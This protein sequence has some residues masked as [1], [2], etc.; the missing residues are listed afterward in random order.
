LIYFADILLDI[1]YS[2]ILFLILVFDIFTFVLFYAVQQYNILYISKSNLDTED[3]IYSKILNQLFL[4]LYIIEIYFIELFCLVR[5]NYNQ[6]VCFK[7][8]VIIILIAIFI[9][10]YQRTVNQNYQLYFEYLSVY[11]KKEV[12]NKNTIKFLKLQKQLFNIIDTCCKIAFLRFFDINRNLEIVESEN[13]IETIA[14]SETESRS[15][16]L[17]KFLLTTI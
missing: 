1:I 4:K 5:D 8:I 7:Q 3:L 9:L 12:N 16:N 6:F 2:V 14:K 13:K 15:D 11:N 10:L 17:F